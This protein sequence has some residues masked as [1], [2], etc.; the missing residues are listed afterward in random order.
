MCGFFS[1]F[2][3]FDHITV[4][5]AMFLI[6]ITN[7]HPANNRL[8]EYI[9][10]QLR[11]LECMNVADPET[12]KKHLKKIVHRANVCYPRCH[13][14]KSYLHTAYTN[15]DYTAGVSELIQFSLYAHRGL[16][17]EPTKPTPAHVDQGE[18]ASLFS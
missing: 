7:S 12:L 8:K 17:E 5:V 16:F 18:Q 6:K 4:I 2:N 9:D 15:G 1:L 11:Q 3:R 10:K 13:P 14:L